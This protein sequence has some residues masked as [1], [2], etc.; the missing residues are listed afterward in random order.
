MFVPRR[1][2][3]RRRGVFNGDDEPDDSDE[4]D[5]PLV[6]ARGTRVYFHAAVTKRT[7]LRLIEALG[8]ASQAAV[9]AGC[10]GV[11]L[12]IHSPGG[13][14]FAGLS[15]AH[16]IRANALPVTTVA[17]GFVASAATFLLLAGAR[18][19]ATA[20]SFVLIHQLSTTFWGTYSTLLDEV[21]N[22][23]ML[24]DTFRRIY[25]ERTNLTHEHLRRL[26]KKELNM[27]AP[28]ALQ[29]GVVDA[30]EGSRAALSAAAGP[31]DAAVAAAAA[32]PSPGADTSRDA[33]R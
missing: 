21:A 10:E 5:A 1:P 28:Q 9:A 4:D 16:H 15:G 8:A 22:S 7:V 18:R 30:I 17:D 2:A 27:S 13:D 24:M 20:D 3:K 23:R 25:L 29:H 12:Y 33:R 32:P 6:V 11:K 19:T 26:L 31:A 14:A